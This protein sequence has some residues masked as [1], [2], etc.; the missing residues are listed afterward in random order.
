MSITQR[1]TNIRTNFLWIDPF[2]SHHSP[3]ARAFHSARTPARLVVVGSPDRRRRSRVRTARRRDESIRAALTPFSSELLFRK[4]KVAV[5]SKPH[6][7]ISKTQPCRDWT[8]EGIIVNY[9]RCTNLST[10]EI[11]VSSLWRFL[12][13]LNSC[14]CTIFC[15]LSS[16][17]SCYSI[18]TQSQGQS[19]S[20][21]VSQLD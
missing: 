16:R 19:L 12:V 6:R 15:S 4:T 8:I 11:G 10:S 3:H 2:C 21:H 7:S 13:E 5:G 18:D 14:T 17:L 1:R 9:S 20:S